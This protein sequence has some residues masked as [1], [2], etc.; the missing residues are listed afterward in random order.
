MKDII[1][2]EKIEQKIY[3]IRRHKVMLDKDLARL[4]GVPTKRLNEQ[5]KRNRRRF[6]DD[7]MFQ[8]NKQEY[9]DLKSHF[10]TSRWGGIRKLP[11]AFTEQGVAMLSSVLHS[12]RAIQ[13]NI[14]I[15]PNLLFLSPCSRQASGVEN[16]L[17]ISSPFKGETTTTA[18][19]PLMGGD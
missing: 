19:P 4:Y 16:Y 8:L 14:V 12:D 13:V 18:S 17:M 3:L 9:N 10:A 1:P 2:L 15:P 5:V 6:P 11:S 7:F